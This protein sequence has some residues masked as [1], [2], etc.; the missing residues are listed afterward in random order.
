MVD[1][2][3]FMN[4]G[5]ILLKTLKHMDFLSPTRPMLIHGNAFVMLMTCYSGLIMRHISIN[6]Q[7]CYITLVLTEQEDDHAGF[8]GERVEQNKRDEARRVD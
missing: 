4:S 1:A 2:M 7:S 3:P 6:W 8:L 5:S